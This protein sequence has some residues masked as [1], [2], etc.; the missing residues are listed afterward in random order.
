MYDRYYMSCGCL[1]G[2]TDAHRVGC[3]DWPRGRDRNGRDWDGNPA[4]P[5]ADRT[6]V[7]V[8]REDVGPQARTE[9]TT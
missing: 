3:P 7:E 4:E 8:I 2:I 5:T 9:A 6:D 1:R